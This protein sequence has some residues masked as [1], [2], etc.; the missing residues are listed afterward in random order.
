LIFIGDEPRES[1]RKIRT[2]VTASN[3]KRP[4]KA[5]MRQKLLGGKVSEVVIIA[6]IV[7][8]ASTAH[9]DGPRGLYVFNWWSWS[10]LALCVE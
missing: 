8:H 9:T 2:A 1:E 5:L 4:V 6:I 10:A 7:G 3:A